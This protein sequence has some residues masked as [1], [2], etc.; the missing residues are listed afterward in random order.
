MYS[1]IVLCISTQLVT[2]EGKEEGRWIAVW[3][4]NQRKETERHQQEEIKLNPA[5]VESRAINL[6]WSPPRK[7]KST[8]RGNV[9]EIHIY[10]CLSALNL[11][12][13]L[14]GKCLN[15]LGS[16]LTPFYPAL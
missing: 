5:N 9:G 10:Y 7:K 1:L 3:H 13:S 4:I 16:N 8:S 12:K 15:T 6:T 2:G 11:Q 14:K